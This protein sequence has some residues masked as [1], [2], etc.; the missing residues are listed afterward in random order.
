MASDWYGGAGLHGG[1]QGDTADLEG[2]VRD[3]EEQELGRAGLGWAGLGWA[4]GHCRSGGRCTAKEEED[5]TNL[6]VQYLSYDFPL[7][8]DFDQD[9]F[10]CWLD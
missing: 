4:G 2:G 5:T 10:C 8:Y 9:I 7:H 1:W 3:G 6:I